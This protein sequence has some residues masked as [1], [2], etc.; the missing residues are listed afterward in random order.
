MKC[1][2][3]KAKFE[4]DDNY[5]S[6]CGAS[7]KG[8]YIEEH[9]ISTDTRGAYEMQSVYYYCDNKDCCISESSKEKAHTKAKL[10]PCPHVE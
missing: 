5:C 2:E 10:N 7:L 3:C 8:N 6:Q 4:S 1:P 9:S